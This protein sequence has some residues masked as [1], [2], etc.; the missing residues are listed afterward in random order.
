[1]HSPVTNSQAKKSPRVSI[2]LP[3]YN[4]ENFLSASI[5][6]ILAQ[7]FPDFELVISDNASS[8]RTE[9]IC[10]HYQALDARIKYDR[11]SRNQG[12]VWN[13]NRVF[14]RSSGEYFMWFSHD[15]LL[16]PSYV[17]RCVAILEMDPS[18]VLC[19]SSCSDI[20]ESGQCLGF[21]KSLIAMDA[22]NPVGRFREGIRLDHLCEPW[23]GLTRSAAIKATPLMGNFADYDRVMIADLGLRGRFCHIPEALYFNREHRN[24]FHLVYAARFERTIEITPGSAGTIVFPHFREFAALWAVVGRAPIPFL[25][26]ARCY[27][28]LLQWAI[29]YRRRL[30]IDFKTAAKEFLR[31][32][33]VHTKVYGSL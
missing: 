3:V 28:L 12:I 19:F 13:H 29:R 2:G 1:M 23:C 33:L 4:G 7:E 22:A 5:E 31:R 11:A 26:S 17:G 24:R 14:E 27:I 6:S 16:A 20:D 30:A 25:Q 10:R 21:R 9:E 18:V 8:D 32:C 15:D